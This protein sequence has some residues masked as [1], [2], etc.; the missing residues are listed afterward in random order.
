M[1]NNK[2]PKKIIRPRG[3]QMLRR[4]RFGGVAVEFAMVAPIFFLVL[5]GG[6][7]FASIHVTQCAIE[8]A[9]FEGVRHGIIPGATAEG[10][11]QQA[12]AI[13]DATRINVYQVTVEPSFIDATTNEISVTVSVPMTPENK[14]GLSAFL[15]GGDLTKTI[16]LPREDRGFN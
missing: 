9:A 1:Q 10:C 2:T 4:T 11:R 6:V 13:L 5:F 14:F 3:K 8:N 15:R 12:E 7:E 16:T